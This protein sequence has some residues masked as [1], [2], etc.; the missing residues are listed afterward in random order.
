MLKNMQKKMERHQILILNISTRRSLE[1]EYK[2]EVSEKIQVCKGNEKRWRNSHLSHIHGRSFR[3]ILLL[4]WFTHPTIYM[5][6]KVKVYTN[7]RGM[8]EQWEKLV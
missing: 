1:D 6:F 5:S 3:S 2:F 4:R 7:G 8:H